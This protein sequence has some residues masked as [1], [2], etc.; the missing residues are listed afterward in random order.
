[1]IP[2]PTQGPFS[3][4]TPGLGLIP[5]GADGRGWFR[6]AEVSSTERFH[7]DDAQV[8]LGGII[9]PLGAGLVLL[10]EIVVLDLAEDPGVAINDSLEVIEDT[11]KGKSGVAD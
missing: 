1:M 6:Q 5:D 9:K 8:S 7:D 10:V 2:D 11:M 4:G 3:R